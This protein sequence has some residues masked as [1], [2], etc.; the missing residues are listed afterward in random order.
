MTTPAKPQQV[1]LLCGVNAA[2]STAVLSARS[3]QA[4]SACSRV[5]C[6]LGIRDVIEVSSG[7]KTGLNIRPSSRGRSARPRSR[8][9]GRPCQGKAPCVA[10]TLGTATTFT[11]L[12]GSGAL[13]G[14]AI[15]RGRAAEFARAPRAGS[16]SFR[17][18]PSTPR[19]RAS[20][21]EH[22]RCH[23]RRAVYGAASL[24]DG[25]VERFAEAL[26]KRRMS[27]SPE[28]LRRSSLPICVSRSS[29]MKALCSMVC[30]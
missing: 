13:V 8:C 4:W 25:M 29:T 3:F 2:A 27:C 23:A 9:G 22:S 20:S 10:V 17:R 7:V 11:A 1:L 12:D 14:S 18:S 16:A 19:T 15:A 28:S 6:A 26:A 5:R 24:M 30:T 21:P